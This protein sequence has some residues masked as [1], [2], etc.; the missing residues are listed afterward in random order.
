MSLASVDA[1]PYVHFGKS[2]IAFETCSLMH[3]GSD[4][5]GVSILSDSS[6]LYRLTQPFGSEFVMITS[7][8]WAPAAVSGPTRSVAF[9]FQATLLTSRPF[10]L[11]PST[12]A[13]ELS[14]M[15]GSSGHTTEADSAFTTSAAYVPNGPETRMP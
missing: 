4:T 7:E 15:P 9:G 11:A 8:V 14:L 2:P 5:T 10:F 12:I 3:S 6:A 1:M 13:C